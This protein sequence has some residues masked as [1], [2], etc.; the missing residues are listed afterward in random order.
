MDGIK[1]YIYIFIL[2][3]CTASCNNR[4]ISFN[5]SLVKIQKSVLMKVQEFG[6]KMQTIPADSLPHTD[7]KSHSER[8]AFFIDQKI[9]EAEN[10]TAPKNGEELKAAMLNQL[11]FEKDIVEKIGN[12]A[13]TNI[14]NEEKAKIETA[15][16]NSEIKAKKLEA[17]IHAVQEAF[18]EKHK[19]KLE[20]K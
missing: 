12:L 15:L 11:K 4:A 3:C 6:D 16:M 9:N 18:A 14:L 2:F 20:N 5:N 7:M 1:N 19:F 8:V 17:N 10:I 13:S